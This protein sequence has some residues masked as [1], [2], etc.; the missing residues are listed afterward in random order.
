MTLV[1]KFNITTSNEDFFFENDAPEILLNN[2]TLFN[3]KADDIID[4]LSDIEI[5]GTNEQKAYL[6]YFKTASKFYEE[7]NRFPNLTE[8]N[9][10]CNLEPIPERNETNFESAYFEIADELHIERRILEYRSAL[11]SKDVERLNNF[12]KSLLN[13]IPTK[14]IDINRILDIKAQ[15]RI[16]RKN[17]SRIIS[18]IKTFDNLTHGFPNK[19][20]NTISAPSSGGKTT[21]AVNMAYKNAIKGKLVVY[22]ALESSADEIMASL[23]S[24]SYKHTLKEDANFL[25]DEFQKYDKI[26]SLMEF[27]PG[28]VNSIKFY[29]LDSDTDDLLIDNYQ[30][31]ITKNNGNIWVI[32]DNNCDLRSIQSFTGTL[33]AIAK[34][35]GQKVD[36]V[37]IDNADELTSFEF[38]GKQDA[39]MTKVNKMINQ[40][41][42]YT[43]T[44][45]NGEGTVILFLAQLN[46]TGINEL[47]K[48]NPLLNMTHISTYSNLYT[49]ASVV[50]VLS[51]TK[52][53]TTT[54]DLRIIKNRHGRKTANDEPAKH[55]VALFTHCYIDSDA[56]DFDI[57][58]Q[59]SYDNEEAYDDGI[60]LD[61]DEDWN[62]TA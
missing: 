5:Y 48:D 51:L 20:I 22:C 62:M 2:L 40:L 8:L 38:D 46:R 49:K 36:L 9:K 57:D 59:D 37:I 44:H 18:G 39:D 56:E 1:E 11:E 31:Q 21:F 13:D 25:K 19:T 23:L 3:D 53:K 12:A 28:T 14:E 26:K 58:K 15:R 33:E 47:E 55:L 4:L 35:E 52:D 16:S 34:A 42:A 32:D 7:Y 60:T 27:Q 24:T 61:D 43:T 50:A 54:L 41:N 10:N 30:K 45:F 6:P 17:K 29:S